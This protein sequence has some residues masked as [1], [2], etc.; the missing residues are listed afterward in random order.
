[1]TRFLLGYVLLTALNL[2]LWVLILRAV[3]WA[4]GG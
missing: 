3:G 4:I 1:M 2:A